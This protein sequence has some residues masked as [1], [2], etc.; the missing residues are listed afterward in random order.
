MKR[1]CVSLQD[2]LTPFRRDALVVVIGVL[3]LSGPLWVYGLQLN[4]PTYRYERVEVH[5]DDSTIEY[6]DRPETGSDIPISDEMACSKHLPGR[7][8]AFEQFLIENRTV[9]TDMYTSSSETDSLLG[10]SSHEYVL[11][12]ETVYRATVETNESGQR[13]EGG[14]RI[15][16]ALEEVQPEEALQD[17]SLSVQSD[18]PSAVAEAA[19]T[20]NATTHER[21]DVPETPIQLESGAYYRVYDA[22]K[23]S[24]SVEYHLIRLAGN[25]LLV[26]LSPLLGLRL[27]VSGPRRF[28]ITYVGD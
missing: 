8:C 24:D 16:L 12:E 14:Y 17:V 1:G 7:V 15:E 27:L 23:I 11:S 18:I 10:G 5:V 21:V 2:F 3:L 22:G 28:E 26:F 9:L 13:D 25:G 6:A 4:E 20:G 19:R